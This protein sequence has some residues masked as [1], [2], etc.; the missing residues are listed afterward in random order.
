MST[1]K[2]SLLLITALFLLSIPA[3]FAA[4]RYPS[5]TETEVLAPAPRQEEPAQLIE[6]AQT[7]WSTG[8]A[9]TTGSRWREARI[10]GQN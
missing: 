3:A 2:R 4:E 1:T 7:T 8:D 10:N 5:A 9:N 6:E